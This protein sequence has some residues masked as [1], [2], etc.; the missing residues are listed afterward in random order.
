MLHLVVGPVFEYSSSIGSSS[1]HFQSLRRPVGLPLF[2]L[3]LALRRLF[4]DR[5]FLFLLPADCCYL[6][7]LRLFVES[8]SLC[9]PMVG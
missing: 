3:T 9:L 2:L 6:M 1:C 8:S 7:Q 4:E 5:C